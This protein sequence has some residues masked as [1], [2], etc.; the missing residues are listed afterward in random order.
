MR[1]A[2]IYGLWKQNALQ[3]RSTVQKKNGLMLP[4]KAF[5]VLTYFGKIF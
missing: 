4:H 5:A 1:N 2:T 3:A